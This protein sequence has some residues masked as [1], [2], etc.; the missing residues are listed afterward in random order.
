MNADKVRPIQLV[1]GV[2][3]LLPWIAFTL[4]VSD[5]V[6]PT[7]RFSAWPP[8]LQFTGATFFGAFVVGELIAGIL[9]FRRDESE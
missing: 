3:W 5:F 6:P 2:L 8:L 4:V 9:Y 1:L 7:W